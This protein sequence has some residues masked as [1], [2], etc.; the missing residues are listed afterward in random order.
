[1]QQLA[2]PRYDEN[3]EASLI[4]CLFEREHGRDKNNEIRVADRRHVLIESKLFLTAFDLHVRCAKRCVV[5]TL[6]HRLTL[7]W[8]FYS[9]SMQM[10]HSNHSANW[11]WRVMTAHQFCAYRLSSAEI[12]QLSA[13]KRDIRSKNESNWITLLHQNIKTIASFGIRSRFFVL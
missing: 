13:M 6:M 12:F 4:V 1:M 2:P 7:D 8:C 5:I 10:W 11:T 9:V 3:N